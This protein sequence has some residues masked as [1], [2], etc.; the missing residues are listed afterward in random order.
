[1]Y[2]GDSL[3]M[4]LQAHGF[5]KAEAMPAGQ[6]KIIAHEP[7]DLKERASESIYVEAEKPG[8]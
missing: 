1:M 3:S 8:G 7:L 4:L 6:T 5:I 2:D